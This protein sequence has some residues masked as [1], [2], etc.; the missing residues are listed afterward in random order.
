MEEYPVPLRAIG[1]KDQF[2]QVGKLPYLKEFY[3]MRTEDIVSSA[4]EVISLKK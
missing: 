3:N 4:K 1:I 2:G